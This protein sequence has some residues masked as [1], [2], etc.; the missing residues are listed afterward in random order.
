MLVAGDEFGRTQLGNN[1]AYCQDNKISWV[2]W[3][4]IDQDL[5]KFTK[6]VI[7]IRKNNPVFYRRKWFQGE[8]IK[9]SGIKDI[10]WFLPEG[11]EMEDYNWNEDYARS[12]GVFLN[13]DAIK[14]A[15]EIGERII[16]HNFYIVFNAHSQPLLYKL[17][18]KPYGNLWQVV[19]NTTSEAPFDQDQFEAGE[20]FMAPGRCIVVLTSLQQPTTN[21]WHKLE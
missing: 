16:G 12:L 7:E 1:N 17:P 21:N 18:D 14:G 20:R 8:S 3:Q 6:K 19:L 15:S 4:S 5:L 9:D 10:N 13:G 11:F 2:D